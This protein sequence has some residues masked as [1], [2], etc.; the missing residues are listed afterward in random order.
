MKK[1]IKIISLALALAFCA[2]WISGCNTVEGIGQDIEAGGAAIE[3][4]AN[5][6]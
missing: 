4:A 6:D 3:D 2:A 1:H 5:G